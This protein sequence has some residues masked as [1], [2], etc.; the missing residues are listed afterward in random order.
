MDKKSML[1]IIVLVL[2]LLM[3][4]VVAF[5][6]ELPTETEINIGDIENLEGYNPIGTLSE[7]ESELL[8]EKS[9]GDISP[10]LLLFP[11][12]DATVTR[13][14]SGY[15]WRGWKVSGEPG[16]TVA[17]SQ[18]LTAANGWNATIGFS[19]AKLSSTVGY[20]VNYSTTMAAS[21][22]KPI[23]LGRWGH[24]GY[25]DRYDNT[26]KFLDVS[27]TWFE[28]GDF[29]HTEHGTSRT[30]QWTRFAFYYGETP[31]ANILPPSPH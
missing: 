26:Y 20:S 11:V 7:T 25:D 13:T 18:S 15:H 30:W 8:K 9:E 4:S 23:P 31:S 14:T 29:S 12:Y 6:Q 24:I 5:A 1:S 17:L 10:Q 19:A 16:G 28:A 22:S 27:I 3:P 2:V 21:Y